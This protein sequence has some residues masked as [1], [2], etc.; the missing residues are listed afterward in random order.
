MIVLCELIAELFGI[1]IKLMTSNCL[2]L[3]Q[4]MQVVKK[5]I[6]KFRTN[7]K[8]SPLKILI[9]QDGRVLPKNV[10]IHSKI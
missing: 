8:Y 9:S 2:V 7:N 10:T 1:I 5:N 3:K 6:E 4:M